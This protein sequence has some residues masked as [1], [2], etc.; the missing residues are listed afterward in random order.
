M[1]MNPATFR[2]VC[3]VLSILTILTGG[4]GMAIS[5]LFLAAG[6]IPD[7]T[8]GA[9]GFI[10][11]SVMIGSGLISLTL[12]AAREWKDDTPSDTFRHPV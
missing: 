1:S 4:G 6:T 12:L 10:A 3:L 9:A 5:F 8:A 11:G 2:I 7:S